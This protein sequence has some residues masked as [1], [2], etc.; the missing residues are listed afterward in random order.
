MTAKDFK[1]DFIGI[2]VNKAATSWI[3]ACLNE[4]PDICISKPKE[5]HYFTSN[6]SLGIDYYKKCFTESSE[7]LILGEYSPEYFN[8]P[9]S[10]ERIKQHNPNIKLILCLRNPVDRLAS[11]FYFNKYN[12][13]H[14]Y[15]TIKEKLRDDPGN[16]IEKGLYAKQLIKLYSIFP[17]SQVLVVFYEDIRHSQ[18]DF[19]RKIFQYLR[20]DD[21][22]VPSI[23]SDRINET[24]KNKFKYLWLNR[25]IL[26]TRK[27]IK[28]A[29]L[30]KSLIKVVRFFRINKIGAWLMLKNHKKQGEHINKDLDIKTGYDLYQYFK[31]DIANLEIMLDVDLSSWK[32]SYE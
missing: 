30:G 22:F 9:E 7:K 27:K 19:I 25:L 10:F 24:K 8:H 5:T 32:V 23:I 6:N 1:V 14:N 2:G 13:K 11:S 21:T 17:K 18:K 29:T 31:E 3:A 26:Q 16:D 20:V 4:H 28:K 15:T 12:G